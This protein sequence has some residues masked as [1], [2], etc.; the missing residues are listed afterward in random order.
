MCRVVVCDVVVLNG[1][2]ACIAACSKNSLPTT[3]G[4]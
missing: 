2:A 3:T 1:G 4:G